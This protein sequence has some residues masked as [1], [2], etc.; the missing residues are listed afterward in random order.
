MA[1]HS[2]EQL[3][4]TFCHKGC[5][6]GASSVTIAYDCQSKTD[7]TKETLMSR[8]RNRLV[9]SLVAATALALSGITGLAAA[10]A[11][12]QIFAGSC[13]APK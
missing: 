5:R 3:L 13:C 12:T 8:S 6:N 9:V 4:M 2:S 10:D 11:H 1:N 7:L